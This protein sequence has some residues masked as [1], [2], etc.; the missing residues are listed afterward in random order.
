MKYLRILTCLWMVFALF[1][2]AEL[3]KADVEPP[4]D[5][6]DMQLVGQFGGASYAVAL[7]GTY[8]YVGVGPRLVVLDVSDAAN[9][10]LVGQTDVLPD[11]VK[12]V[13]VASGYAYVAAGPRMFVV[14][15]ASPA[16]PGIVGFCTAPDDVNGLAVSGSYA[17]L[18][19]KNGSL[20]I[21]N[22]STPA[23]PSEVGSRVVAASAEAQSVA[24]AGGFAY[25]VAGNTLYS[26]NVTTPSSPSPSG[27]LPFTQPLQDVV[28]LGSTAYLAAGSLGLRI[29]DVA[30]PAT[31]SEVGFYD[32]S[33][34][35]Y[36]VA[37][38]NSYAYVA[39]GYQGLQI[40]NVA[41]PSTPVFAGHSATQEL[42]SDVAVLNDYAYVAD[43][44]RGLRAFD[45]STPASPVEIGHYDIVGNARRVLPVGNLL[46]VADD[47]GGM[48]ILNVA[49]P[50]RPREIGYYDSPN[51]VSSM[52]VAGQYAYVADGAGGVR[53]VDVTDP[54]A[55]ALV[56]TFRTWDGWV[57]G[58]I[59][60]NGYAYIAEGGGTGQRRGLHI[61]SL[62][63]PIAP[64][65]EE[66]VDTAG[67]AFDLALV[68]NRAYVA[69][70][71]GGL[72]IVDVTT[73]V[74]PVPLGS[75]DVEGVNVSDVA[76][77]GTMAYVVDGQNL[78]AV[79]TA[80]P[81]AP[82]SVM[83][84]TAGT[85]DGVTVVNSIAY[86][87]EGGSGLR[88]LDVT[89]PSSPEEI[90]YY[91]TPGEAL[92]SALANQYIYVADGHGGVIV[93]WYGP[94]ATGT[95]S[96]GGGAFTSEFDGTT[97]YFPA[98]AFTDTIILRHAPIPAP[99]V[100]PLGDLSG[101]DHFFNTTAVYSSTGQLAQLV[102]GTVFTV[103]VEYTPEERGV[104]VDSTLAL[105]YWDGDMWSTEGITKVATAQQNIVFSRLDHL[106]LFGVLGEARS[107]YLPL[108]MRTF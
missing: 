14:N 100:P 34:S 51:N 27:S 92:Y 50:G 74:I 24:V 108:V 3:V 94:L 53:I 5:A 23:N 2:S 41:I 87:A 16:V 82:S 26:V 59:I 67:K 78:Y 25:I 91:N 49:N 77:E 90:G 4:V 84:W 44:F 15:I 86:L 73:P 63:N 29:V 52:A 98:G 30:A 97:Y 37:V 22:V 13:V 75:W 55:P 79:N 69:A 32:T 89:E 39:D 47:D 33:G 31:P 96:T 54:S 88:L 76:V 1:A 85:A 6:V 104:V 66:F 46:Y 93:L 107:I 18:A 28:V 72:R 70:D 61:A 42:A 65:T 95:V 20:R 106:T 101:I 7:Q 103:S 40:I 71:T 11:I 81:V 38:A 62:A 17:Y 80:N 10:L 19:V 60:R 9:P 83:T 35:A 102:P 12:D 36:G 48:R 68:G 105:Y 8:A 99:V 56:S 45:V 58:I 43:R 64:V 57:Y 21:V